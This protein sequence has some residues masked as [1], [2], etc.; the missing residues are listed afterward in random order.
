ML[1]SGVRQVNKSAGRGADGG[2]TPLWHA[3]REGHQ[4]VVD[5]LLGAG[6]RVDAPT[7]LGG[8][9]LTIAVQCKHETV[10][11]ALLHAGA[12]VNAERNDGVT[13]LIIAAACGHETVWRGSG[14][15][16]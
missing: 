7:N 4:A 11:D 15:R 2:V 9:P 3:A 1:V 12:R 5:I 6:A 8:T 16:V 13:S 10:V 14:F